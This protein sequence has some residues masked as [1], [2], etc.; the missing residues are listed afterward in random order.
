MPEIDVF[1]IKGKGEKVFIM[2][3]ASDEMMY[4]E[5]GGIPAFTIIKEELV[6]IIDGLPQTALF[7]VSVFDKWKAY[8]MFPKLVPA[9]NV[10]VA[11]VEEWLKPLNAVRPGMGVDEWGTRTLGVGGMQIQE[12]FRTGI[13]KG[14]ESWHRPTML[15]MKQQA[16]AVFVLT[17]WWGYQRFAESERDRE[18]FNTSKGKRYLEKAAEALQKYDQECRDRVA[19]G[20]APRVLN[21]HDKRLLVVTYFPGTELPPEPEYYYHKPEEYIKGMLEVRENNKKSVVQA[22]SGF[23]NKRGAKGGFSFNVVRF[24]RVDEDDSYFRNGRSIENFKKMTG[25]L[26]GDYREIAGLEAIKS[27]VQ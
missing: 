23:R 12:D 19:Q 27:S 17:S 11:K 4:D 5:M 16:D 25:Y 14:T 24:V 6:K 18:W 8:A 20:Q 9:N 13:F 15:A 10:N 22:K 2:L 3:D 26:G 7:N 1:G 21:R